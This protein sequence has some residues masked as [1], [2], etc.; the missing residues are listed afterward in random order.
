[1]PKNSTAEP[2][3]EV[4]A[5]NEHEVRSSLNDL[6]HKSTQF[7]GDIKEAGRAFTGKSNE[8]R[9]DFLSALIKWGL[10]LMEE[11]N[12]PLRQRIVEEHGLTESDDPF[13]AWQ[14]LAF[15]AMSTSK[16]G[17]WTVAAR[18]HERMGAQAYYIHANP[19]QYPLQGLA[20]KL[21]E[22]GAFSALNNAMK[23]KLTTNEKSEISKRR[24][25]IYAHDAKSRLLK[26]PGFDPEDRK[27]GLAL[28]SLHHGALKILQLP[29][30]QDKLAERLAD[31]YCEGR[32]AA[33]RVELEEEREQRELAKQATTTQTAE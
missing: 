25:L 20:G 15:V 29:K 14:N 2:L 33:L 19:E 16:D 31:K 13:R 24:D 6:R 12:W 18:R 27:F 4:A 22:W 10:P 7:V 32:I 17:K 28:V 26:W 11:V 5:I 9:A 1:M 30:G 23:P 3:M 8:L 21:S